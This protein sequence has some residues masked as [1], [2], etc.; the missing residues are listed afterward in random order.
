M[1][2]TSAN[3]SERIPSYA[4]GNATVIDSDGVLKWRL[5]NLF[6]NSAVGATQSVTVVSGADYTIRFKGTGSITYSGAASGTLSGTGASDKVSVEVTAST[7]T[8]TCTVSGSITEVAVYRSDLGG[9]QLSSFDG[10]DYI[11]TTGSPVYAL[12][13]DYSRGVRETLA[14]TAVT[15][16]FTYAL[17]MDNGSGW[18]GFRTNYT[19]GDEF[20]GTGINFLTGTANA[21]NSNGSAVATQVRGSL[22][23]GTYTLSVYAKAGP[24]NPGFLLIRPTDNA[25]FA[26]RADA[27]FDIAGG[28]TETVAS[29][30]TNFTSATSGI[31]EVITG[32]YRCWITFTT[33]AT[34]TLANSFYVVDA[35]ASLTTTTGKDIQLC[36]AQFEAWH[37]ATSFIPTTTAAV[38]RAKDEAYTALP[39]SFIQGSGSLIFEGSVG[40]N[41]GGSSFP[42]IMQMDNGSDAERVCIQCDEVSDEMDVL[43]VSSSVTQAVLSR[44]I[45]SGTVTKIALR[46]TTNDFAASYDGN[47]ALTDTN[48]TAPVGLTTLRFGS[49]TGTPCTIRLRDLRIGPYS[50]PTATP[51]W[52]DAYLATISG[53]SL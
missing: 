34:L 37:E 2:G 26:N 36:G 21:T 23:A 19:A 17:D 41:A 24:S 35:D 14:E 33:D 53:G 9:M 44:S 15:N 13:R 48:G 51:G 31:E 28:T 50:S 40:Y 30:G 6:L 45:A 7:T 20:L 49:L 38:A 39:S 11:A 32:V 43:P 5:H 16:Q 52:D 47:A 10:T 3:L 42:R 18:L 46:W 12:R 4:T 25:S 22:A 1:S 29:P 8:L 27:W